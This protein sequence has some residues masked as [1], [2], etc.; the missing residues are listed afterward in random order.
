MPNH[1]RVEAEACVVENRSVTNDMATV[2]LSLS[3]TAE[4]KKPRQVLDQLSSSPVIKS[5]VMNDNLRQEVNEDAV[6]LI[7]DEIMS[8]K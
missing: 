6:R 7:F 8:S 4:Q 3:M 1:L 2:S 5:S